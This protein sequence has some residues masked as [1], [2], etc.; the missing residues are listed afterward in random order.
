VCRS[1]CQRRRKHEQPP[2]SAIATATVTATAPATPRPTATPTATATQ[3]STATARPSPRN[4]DG[5]EAPPSPSPS[6]S[7]KWHHFSGCK[8]SSSQLCCWPH[9]ARHTTG[10]RMAAHRKLDRR[11]VC[12]ARTDFVNVH[13]GTAQACLDHQSFISSRNHLGGLAVCSS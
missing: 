11:R 9:S 7:P 1:R 5:K 12:L 2:A 4:S 8:T 13:K 3:T 6:E 10:D